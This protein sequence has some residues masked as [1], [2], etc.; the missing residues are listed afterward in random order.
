M[1]TGC[2]SYFS[3]CY[4]EN[5]QE[6]QVKEGRVYLAQSLGEQFIVVEAMVAGA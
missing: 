3:Y 5:T 6:K 2:L 1:H 4:D